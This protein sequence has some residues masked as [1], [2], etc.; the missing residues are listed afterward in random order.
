MRNGRTGTV[1]SS[2]PTVACSCSSTTVVA[3]VAA[4]A[5][6]PPR[7]RS[8]PASARRR[9]S[10]PRSSLRE[11][12]QTLGVPAA[13]AGRALR[14]ASRSRVASRGAG[15]GDLLLGEA[16]DDVRPSRARERE[17]VGNFI[18]RSHTV[19]WPRV[20]GSVVIGRPLVARFASDFCHLAPGG[21]VATR[22]YGFPWLRLVGRRPCRHFD[23][24]LREC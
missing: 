19:C 23:Q 11:L 21:R 17:H 8:A 7:G 3:W 13:M 5:R 18:S 1:R 9:H 14:T 15:G 4:R 20:A 12:L 6:G 10:R 16:R 24:R 22:V 2:T